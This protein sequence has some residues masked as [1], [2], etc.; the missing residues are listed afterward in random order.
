MVDLVDDQ[1][2]A[3]FVDEAVL[4][5]GYDS[6]CCLPLAWLYLVVETVVIAVDIDSGAVVWS[7]IDW[8][9]V[10]V[11][12]YPIWGGCLSRFLAKKLLKSQRYTV[13]ENNC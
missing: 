1:V 11:L 10:V 8:D 3:G 9:F 6:D 5:G 7:G 2:A 12:K 13:K 4:S